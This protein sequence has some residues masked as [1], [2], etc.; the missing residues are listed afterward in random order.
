MS[1]EIFSGFM[2]MVNQIFITE[3]MTMIN[4]E[5]DLVSAHSLT[6]ETRD[7]Q[8]NVYSIDKTDLMRLYFLI[9]KILS[10]A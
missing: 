6:L 7:G 1:E 2:P 9:G 5:G 4:T 3:E 8:K 10:G